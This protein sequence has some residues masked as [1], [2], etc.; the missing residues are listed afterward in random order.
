MKDITFSDKRTLFLQC[1][2]FLLFSTMMIPY[3][4]Y[5]LTVRTVK[6]HFSVISPMIIDSI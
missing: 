2:M 3:Y 4:E 5:N 1:D 6:S